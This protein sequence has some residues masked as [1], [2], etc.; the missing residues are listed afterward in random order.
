MKQKLLIFKKYLP[1]LLLLLWADGFSA[2]LLWLADIDSFMTLSIVILLFSL[3]L[4]TIILIITGYIEQKKTQ[5]FLTFITNPDSYN[6]ENLI[7]T[8]PASERD[9]L[10]VLGNILREQ[11]TAINKSSTDLIEYEEYAESW[12]HETKIPLSLLTMILDNRSDEMS[13]AVHRKLEYSRNRIQENVNQMLYYAR[14]NSPRKDYLFEYVEISSCIQEA[15]ED[16]TPLLEEKNFIIENSVTFK[17]VFTDKRGIIFILSQV[18]SNSVK[19]CTDTDAPRLAFTLSHTE[20]DDKLTIAD[21]G[22]GVKNCDLPYIFEKG[23]TGDSYNYDK[24]STGMGLYLSKKLAYELN[25]KLEA[26]SEANKGFQLTII[27]PVINR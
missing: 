11:Q 21:N 23:F 24:K 7:K 10:R 9:S 27:F 22:I 4:F 1:W 26:H 6:E 17:Q 13:P 2:L 25:I 12:A 15:L 20:K 3:L 16:Y 8:I 5:T 14:L 18:I 19:Y